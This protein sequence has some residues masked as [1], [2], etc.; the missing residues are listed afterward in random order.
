MVCLVEE[1]KERAPLMVLGC[2]LEELAMVCLR[3]ELK[4]VRDE[5]T[6]DLGMVENLS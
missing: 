1:R 2:L 5:E 4:V 6:G 3:E